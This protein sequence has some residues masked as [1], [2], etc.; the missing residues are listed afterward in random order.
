MK[1]IQLIILCEEKTTTLQTLK[2]RV[3]Q[4]QQQQQQHQT[5]YGIIK[6][7]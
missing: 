5:L 4:H 7:F 2:Q 1:L 3:G 6:R